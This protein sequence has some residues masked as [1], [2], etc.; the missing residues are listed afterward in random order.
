MKMEKPIIT[1]DLGFAR[2]ICQD[3]ALYFKPRDARSAVEQIERLL[4]NPVLQ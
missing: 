4:D 1:S 3:A 2:S